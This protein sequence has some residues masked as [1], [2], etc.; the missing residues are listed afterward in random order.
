VNLK[1]PFYSFFATGTDLPLLQLGSTKN[2][3]ENREVH[4]ASPP[5][6]I[7]RKERERERNKT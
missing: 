6:G 2:G 7:R 1:P 4:A 3:D 5:K